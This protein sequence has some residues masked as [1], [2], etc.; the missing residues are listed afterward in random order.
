M[1]FRLRP[2]SRAMNIFVGILKNYYERRWFGFAV[3]LLMSTL[4]IALPI[5]L[6]GIRQTADM[7]SHIHFAQTFEAGIRSG[8]FYPGWANDNL[9]FGSVGIRFYPPAAAFTSAL[10]RIATGE[11]HSAFLLSLFL[12]MTVGCFGMYLFVREWSSSAHGM[13]AA[14]LYAVMPYQIAHIY[15]FFLY[16]E[17]AAMAAVPFCLLFLTR[18]CRR[19]SW[20]DLVP[21]VLSWSVL[22]L[23]H[24]P[25]TLLTAFS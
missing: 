23:T 19:G 14:M 20:A 10:F 8:D 22:I 3:A 11:W 24:I 18:L 6:G 5:W 17:F 2:P 12:W 7:E 21:L 16:A 15:R 1:L 13:F 4:T 25:V 9:G